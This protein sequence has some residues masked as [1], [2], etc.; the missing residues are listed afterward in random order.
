MDSETKEK[1]AKAVI[2]L[3]ISD[4]IIPSSLAWL[5]ASPLTSIAIAC[6]LT[7]CVALWGFEQWRGQLLLAVVV[8]GTVS[9]FIVKH[10]EGYSL[11]FELCN[12]EG[13]DPMPNGEL[14]LDVYSVALRLHNKSDHDIWVKAD[15]NSFSLG[16]TISRGPTDAPPQ[17]IDA[18]DASHVVSNALQYDPPL[19]LRNVP[20]GRMRV[21]LRYGRTRHD[22]SK[23]LIFSGKVTIEFP[24]NGASLL[25]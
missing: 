19:P 3:A 21:V 17:K 8:V 12:S 24:P 25:M 15:D 22:L 23:T 13:Y 6:V 16:D 18:G 1:V 5:G 10:E 7:S 2:A 9:L 20:D 4:V 11:P 14:A